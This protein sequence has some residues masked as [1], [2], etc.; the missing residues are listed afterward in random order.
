MNKKNKLLFII[1]CFIMIPFT[2]FAKERDYLGETFKSL[3]L[4]ETLDEEGI[5]MSYPDYT[6]DDN[7]AVIYMFRGSGCG[8][9]KAFLTFLNSIVPE[10]GKYFKLESYEVWYDENNG[11]LMLGVASYLNKEAGG[12]PFIIIGDKVFEGYASIYDD[13]I[14]N[15]IKNLYDT[16]KSDRYDVIDSMETDKYDLSTIQIDSGDDIDVTSTGDEDSYSKNINISN[17]IIW[18]FIFTTISTVVIILFV[19]YKFKQLESEDFKFRK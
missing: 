8:Y 9:C 3:N 10:Y 2:A 13:D 1:I 7:Q 5:E 18:N 19:N 17:D 14:K 15:A 16:N 11:K 4:K 6:E 12:V